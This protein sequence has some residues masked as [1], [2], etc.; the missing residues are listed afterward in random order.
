MSVYRIGD[1]VMAFTPSGPLTWTLDTLDTLPH[2]TFSGREILDATG[3]RIVPRGPEMTM[4]SS[5]ALTDIDNIAATGA[6]A[7]RVLL[8]VDA[9][10][11][12]TPELFDQFFAKIQQ[13]DMIAWV[14]FYAW[15]EAANFAIAPALG[16]GNFFS[17]TAPEGY[18]VCSTD[19]HGPCYLSMW[20]RQW[21][22]DL[23]D[24]YRSYVIL[25]AM[26]EYIAPSGVE[27]G[28]EA[29]RAA[30]RDA[31]ISSVEFFRD[32]GYTQPLAVMASFQ[33]RDLYGITQHATAILNAD[34]IKIGGQSQIIFG[35][36]A[37]WSSVGSPTFYPSWQGSLLLGPGQSITATQAIDT[38][39]PTL[40]YPV[41]AGFD[42]YADDTASDW[43]IQIEAAE[44][45]DNA[46]LW[47]DW[48]NGQLDCPL[49]GATCRTYVLTSQAGFAGARTALDDE[50]APVGGKTLDVYYNLNSLY[51]HAAG[52][53][54][55]NTR[56][57][58]WIKRMADD[59]PG[60]GNVF[61]LGARFGFFTSWALA[62]RASSGFEEVSTPYI[63]QYAESWT[64]AQ[65]IEVVAFVPDN[66]DG[67]LFDPAVNTNM[68]ASY[69]T[70]LLSHIDAWE[71]NAAN[72]NRRYVVY[73]GWP[74]LNGYGGTG[75]DPTTVNST[76]YANW[77][78][79]GL[80]TYQTWMELLVSRLQ[81]ARPALDIRL[82]NVSKAVLL[83]YRDTVVSGIP[84]TS[85]FEDLAPHGRSTWYFLAAVA[86]YIELYNEKPP[87]GFTFDGAWGVHS[88]V[89]SNYQALV[90]HIWGV[91]RP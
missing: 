85:L 8:G 55:L 44:R 37:Y 42:N 30:W 60:G 17:Q 27:A 78:A 39:L 66:F 25:D 58:N 23:M 76:G 24:K 56:V 45:Q 41:Q 86:E 28:S 77:I 84:V 50:G 59:A 22:K 11:N 9:V 18:G 31:A 38:I 79:F 63:D 51:N 33:G 65:N 57:G 12:M 29:G 34:T 67:V 47:W 89:T 69:Q 72:A 15:N 61:T 75:D 26:Q 10:N 32:R 70:V 53:G 6:N 52:A 49:D 62:P 80:G 43:Q 3:A 36:Q 14:S 7:V 87:A 73:A 16:G 88:T 2:I 91:L 90:D 64:G 82:H 5:A 1:Q 40:P 4:A 83:T 81:A 46:W 68:G 71:A 21:V 74:Q 19:S 20:D 48:R 13:H 35:W 54:N